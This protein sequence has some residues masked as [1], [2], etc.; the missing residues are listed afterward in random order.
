MIT[1]NLT[2]DSVQRTLDEFDQLGR[3]VFL[4]KYSFG[5]ARSYFVLRD[6]KRYDSKAIAGVAQKHLGERA[7]T[8]SDFSGG[9]IQV[10]RGLRKL[11]FEVTGP[12]AP[13]R[14]DV[15]F[16][17][18]QIYHRQKDIHGPYG[19]QERGGIATPVSVPFVF[20]FTGESGGAYG[21][22]DGWQEDGSFEYTG[23]GQVG[24]MELKKGNR[25]IFE[26]AGDSKELLLFKAIKKKGYYQFKGVFSCAGYKFR[27]TPDRENHVR[28][29]IV[30]SLV[31]TA[32]EANVEEA[33]TGDVD[34]SLDMN[35]L[36]NLAYD[37]GTDEV[38]T[39]TRTSVV[40]YRRRSAAVKAYVLLR[41]AGTCE[42]C[43]MPAPFLKRDGSP[44][45]EPHH[46]ARLADGGADLPNAVAAICPTC[47]RRIHH[48][49]GG[50]ELNEQL[51]ERIERKEQQ[52]RN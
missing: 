51:I 49:E 20:L 27:E 11:G 12:D 17:I 4:E 3:D 42:C 19:G 23:E 24:D 13:F 10:A 30:F 29:S 28:K 1:D 43:D 5:K 31:P 44:Y 37:R 21:Y 34:S 46:T 48:G 32:F 35:Q 52:I 33:E 47:H 36:R 15:P 14:L 50:V 40:R 25:A 38:V 8:T 45:L 39:D 26:H 2:Q 7:L 9:E 6:G 18:G 41:A 22:E 16:K